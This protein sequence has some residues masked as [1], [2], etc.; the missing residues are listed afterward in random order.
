[1]KA[2]LRKDRPLVGGF[3]HHAMPIIRPRVLSR[4]LK[5]GESRTLGPRV[6]QLSRARIHRGAGREQEQNQGGSASS[7]THGHV[8][9]IKRGAAGQSSCSPLEHISTPQ[10]REPMEERASD[11]ANSRQWRARPTAPAR[12][13]GGLQDGSHGRRVLLR[14]RRRASDGS[15]SARWCA[16]VG[17][18]Q[19]GPVAAHAGQLQ[20]GLWCARRT[21]PARPRWRVR[22]GPLQLGPVEHAR[23]LAVRKPGK[24]ARPGSTA[25]AAPASP[26]GTTWRTPAGLAWGSAAM[27]G[28]RDTPRSTLLVSN[29]PSLDYGLSVGLEVG[30]RP[31]GMAGR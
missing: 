6:L 24:G 29:G 23:S 9:S 16:R 31:G 10:Q 14:P 3:P 5:V 20:L 18:L 25:L 27:L 2:P 30:G 12:A 17:Q 21:A 8:R 11:S 15:S 19:L 22:V 4:P 1:M 7:R 13:G 28:R 26:P